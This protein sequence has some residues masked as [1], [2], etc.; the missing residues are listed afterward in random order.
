[1]VKKLTA[2]QQ[3]FVLEFLIDLNG[4]Q[5]AIRA[6]YSPKGAERQAVRMSGNVRVQAAIQK[7]QQQRAQRTE[8]T[9]DYVALEIKRNYEHCRRLRIHLDKNQ[10]AKKV[11]NEAGEMVDDDHFDIAN[12]LRLLEMMARHTGFYDADKSGS[13]VTVIIGDKDVGTL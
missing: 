9:Q 10:E 4:T 2:K 6:G 3:R 1:M 12:S 7:A 11:M 8:L 5:A 13:G